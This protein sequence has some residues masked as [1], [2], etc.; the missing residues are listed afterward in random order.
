MPLP[1]YVQ[2]YKL[3]KKTGFRDTVEE[4]FNSITRKLYSAK[5]V[6]E[7]IRIIDEEIEKFPKNVSVYNK[8]R[9]EL[10]KKR[11]LFLKY[12]KNTKKHPKFEIRKHG[13]GQVCL[14]GFPSAGKS[15]LMKLITNAD[16]EIAEYAFTTKQPYSG[17]IQ[18]DGCQIQLI[19]IPGIME[20]AAE[21]YGRG[22]RFLSLVRNCNVIC[23]LVALNENPLEKLKMLKNEVCKMNIKKQW[24]AIGTK[25][26]M[27]EPV[28][29]LICINEKQD[30]NFLKEMFF[31]MM[32]RIRVYTKEP[33]KKP[34]LK[35]PTVLKK[36]A[37]V[38]DVAN[39]LDIECTYAKLWGSGKFP[40]QRISRK[41]VLQDR[42]VIELHP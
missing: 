41:Y 2:R 7:R 30:L 34:D 24:I 3:N 21:G 33:R 6:A 14:I 8:K 39:K 26:D 1:G 29:G 5:T 11:E 37:T 9:K 32:N 23:Y 10:L 16:P 27:A 15:T 38:A 31:Q 25:S 20:K 12:E 22:K 42:D 13:I 28:E 35:E 17:M 19:E 18:I 36:P 4:K 40:S